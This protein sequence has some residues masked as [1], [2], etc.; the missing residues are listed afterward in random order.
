MRSYEFIPEAISFTQYNK[1]IQDI[2]EQGILQSVESFS[3]WNPNSSVTNAL[4]D[5]ETDPIRNFVLRELRKSLPENISSELTKLAQELIPISS[6]MTRVTGKERTKRS[7][8]P[9]LA[10]KIRGEHGDRPVFP[11]HPLGGKSIQVLFKDI[12]ASGGQANGIIISL[13]LRYIEQIS[14][15]IADYIVEHVN[16]YLDSNNDSLLNAF[17][18]LVHQQARYKSIIHDS[19]NLPDII[20]KCT[21]TV[22]HE[23]VHV[24]QHVTQHKMGRQRTEYRGY[25]SSIRD[26]HNAI[27]KNHSKA[28]ISDEER[29]KNYRIYRASPQE[30]AAFAHQDALKF[31][32]DNYIDDIIAS[33][34]QVEQGTIQGLKH[35]INSGLKDPANPKEQMVHNRYAKLVY[36]EVMRY[37]EHVKSQQ[38]TAK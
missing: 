18:S 28:P 25:T 7:E 38:N 29:D 33:G 31:I 13:S 3:S 30:M 4:D 27:R 11:G 20:A 17:F 8:L 6:A 9:R 26:F 37:I 5:G 24:Q 10:G 16:D 1:S 36:Q 34:D 2:I 15:D 35:Y 19:R 22:I 21:S 12:G 32:Q 14:K 23:L